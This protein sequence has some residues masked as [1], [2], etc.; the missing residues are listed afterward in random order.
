[1]PAG[2]AGLVRICASAGHDTTWRQ[3]RRTR[4]RHLVRAI[5][6]CALEIAAHLPVPE[7]LTGR[8]VRSKPLSV[9][10]STTCV[11]GQRGSAMPGPGGFARLGLRGLT[12]DDVR[13][14]HDSPDG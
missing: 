11:A 3:M 9:S 13:T 1:M 14:G 10:C 12:A 8:S 2:C 4:R 6:V 5:N 7:E